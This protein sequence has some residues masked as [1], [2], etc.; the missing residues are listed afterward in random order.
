[1]TVAAESPWLA[2]EAES[3][4]AE[5]LLRWALDRFHPKIAFASSFGADDVV[6]IHMLAGIRRD[7]RIFTLDTGRLPEETYEV[8]ERIRNR[9]GVVLETHFPDKDEVERLEREKGFYSFRES[10]EN[11]KECCRIRKVE[12]L[13]RAL[14]PDRKSTR[15]NSSH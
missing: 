12:P 5:D 4:N 8:M 6:V 2:E 13:A 14:A 9:Y 11:R 7:V 3:K 10:L 1:M 15:L